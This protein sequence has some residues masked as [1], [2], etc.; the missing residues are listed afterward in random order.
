[1]KWIDLFQFL[2]EQANNLANIGKFNWQK[3]VIIYD[4]SSGQSYK[5]DTYRVKNNNAVLMINLDK[6][7]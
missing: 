2:N 7:W 3:Q 5:C 1:M 6:T 4:A